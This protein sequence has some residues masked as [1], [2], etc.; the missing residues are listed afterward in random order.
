MDNMVKAIQKVELLTINP[1]VPDS[2][3]TYFY[4]NL[5]KLYM[6][7]S[8][9]DVIFA[10]YITAGKKLHF[11]YDIFNSFYVVFS[12]YTKEQGQESCL[13]KEEFDKKQ[14]LS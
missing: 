2:C 6:I 11:S 7:Y 5:D 9:S 10:L 14:Q 4:E 13:A 8:K 1:A 12:P 3:L